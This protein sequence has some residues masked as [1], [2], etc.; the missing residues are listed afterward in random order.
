[1]T[2]R[3]MKWR[4]TGRQDCKYADE[5]YIPYY[6]NLLTD[7]PFYFHH[8][9]NLPLFHDISGQRINSVKV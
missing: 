7:G 4:T 3:R 5:E 8:G 1:M 6:L 9:D 2:S